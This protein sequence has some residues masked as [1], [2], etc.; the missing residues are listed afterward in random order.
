MNLIL[1][2][3]FFPFGTGE[4]FLETEVKYYER[5]FENI[6]I[7][8]L[9]LREKDISVCRNL[10]S[11]KYKVLPVKKVSGII[12]LI[13]SLR[14]IWDVNFYKEFVKLCNTRRF[15]F[16]RIMKLLIYLSR[17]YY[18]A[19]RI[20]K[21]LKEN[22]VYN[23]EEKGV[24]YSYRF[25]YQPY[26]ALLIKNRLPNY[27]V[28]ARGHGFDLYEERRVEKYIPLREFLLEKLDK[29]VMIAQHGVDYL[30]KNYS[31][32]S[33][34]IVLYRLGTLDRGLAI[35]PNSLKTIRIVSCSTVTPV[36]RL[37]L[38]IEALTK[39]KDVQVHWDHYGDG[40]LMTQIKKMAAARLNGNITYV[41]HGHID[42]TSLL[43][44]YINNSY[45]LFI[46]VS[47]SEGIPVSIMEAMSFGVPCIATNVGGTKEIV[48]DGKNGF[49]LSCDFNPSE[50]ADRIIKFAQM[51]KNEYQMFR[52]YARQY[53]NEHFNADRNYKMFMEFLTNL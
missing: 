18:E 13:Y 27:K 48:V 23:E 9:Q 11:E 12:Y 47:S 25:E 19:S 16:R 44:E 40:V 36:K 15:T 14:A 21:W 30:T 6:Y 43:G 50:L 4:P 10:P 38:L 28:I 2:T 52:D 32:Y 41:F 5:Y 35:I 26:V 1:F 34:K 29:T 53:W 45:H 8:S 46:N 20:N 31:T 7:C 22:K 42:N 33:D 49:L 39:V 51:N 17:S 37:H 24:M 3:N